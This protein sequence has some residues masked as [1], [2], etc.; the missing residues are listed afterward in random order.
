MHA[1]ERARAGV[2]DSNPARLR[3]FG[4]RHGALRIELHVHDDGSGLPAF[5]RFG[6]IGRMGKNIGARR[7]TRGDRRR[8]FRSG[9][10]RGGDGG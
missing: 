5:P 1:N 10:G 9:L 6:R 4:L 8:R 2:Q 7:V 3:D